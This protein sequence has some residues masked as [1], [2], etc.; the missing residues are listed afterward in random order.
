MP[1]PRVIQ[2]AFH[3]KMET[4]KDNV[5]I[6]IICSFHLKTLSFY[7]AGKSCPV[8]Q[9]P[10]DGTVISL[11]CGSAYGSQAFLSCNE[12]Y[13][14]AGSRVRSC[15]EDSKWSGNVTTCNSKNEYINNYNTELAVL[16][17]KK[18]AL[19][20]FVT[21]PLQENGIAHDC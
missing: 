6:E 8:L 20:Q 15:E 19:S 7:P 3:F 10:I 14:L 9:P 21:K 1:I 2:T 18:T 12:G 4:I 17:V 13:R 5:M 16:A 11:S